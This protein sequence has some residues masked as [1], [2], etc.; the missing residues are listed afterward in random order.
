MSRRQFEETQAANART[1]LQPGMLMSPDMRSRLG[2]YASVIAGADGRVKKTYED[3]QN[4]AMR[5]AQIAASNEAA[6]TSRMNRQVHGAQLGSIVAATGSPAMTAAD[7]VLQQWNEP[8]PREMRVTRAMMDRTGKPTA[9]I[10][11]PDATIPATI[12]DQA[13]AANDSERAR[14][15]N[16]VAA[17]VKFGPLSSDE[18]ALRAAQIEG[19]YAQKR[20]MIQAL[21]QSVAPKATGPGTPAAPRTPAVGGQLV[22]PKI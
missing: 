10:S 8:I 12:L 21:R 11:L 15:I 2:P 18:G 20:A 3:L 6:A 19:Q 9:A 22:R 7:E 4:E 13:W 17:M 14:K 16:E 5:K 1:F